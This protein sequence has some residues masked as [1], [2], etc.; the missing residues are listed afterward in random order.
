MVVVIRVEG[1][2][3]PMGDEHK[4][5]RSTAMVHNHV[6]RGEEKGDNHTEV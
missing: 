4:V 5:S 6:R 2:C 1:K 3:V